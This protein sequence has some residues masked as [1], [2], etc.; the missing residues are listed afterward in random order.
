MLNPDQLFEDSYVRVIGEGAQMTDQAIIFFRSFYKRFFA[1]SP[2]I[3]EL[4]KATDM[5]KQIQVM[6]KSFFQL[7]SLS[8]TRQANQH[9]LDIARGH[10]KTGLNINPEYYELW[11][12]ALIETVA[13]KDN[14]FSPEVGLS[15]RIALTPG[16]LIMQHYYDHPEDTIVNGR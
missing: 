15:W 7:V 16:V 9:L 14:E 5:D 1:K 3:P 2:K 4:F 8:V 6:Q 10:S 12:D 11:L 13:E